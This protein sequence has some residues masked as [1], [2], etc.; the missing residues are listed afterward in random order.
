MA[1]RRGPGRSP[2]VG[3][4]DRRWG[5]RV[6]PRGSRGGRNAPRTRQRRWPPA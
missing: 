3:R 6:S 2:A 1:S 5:P 4:M